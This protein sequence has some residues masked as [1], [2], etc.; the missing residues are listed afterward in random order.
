MIPLNTLS[1][2]VVFHNIFLIF[3]LLFSK[4]KYLKIYFRM[5]TILYEMLKFCNYCKKNLVTMK[6]NILC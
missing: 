1:T 4:K 5:N 3:E 2:E 6:F